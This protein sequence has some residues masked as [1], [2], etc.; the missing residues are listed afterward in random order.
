MTESQVYEFVMIVIVGAAL[1]GIWNNWV[2][3]DEKM[4][5]FRVGFFRFWFT[6]LTN[7]VG[8]L[9]GKALRKYKK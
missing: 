6:L 7:P 5:P 3:Y 9:N 8:A 2:L 1:V 4:Y